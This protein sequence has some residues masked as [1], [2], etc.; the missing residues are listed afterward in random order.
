MHVYDLRDRQTGRDSRSSQQTRELLDDGARSPYG[1]ACTHE[2][3]AVVEVRLGARHALLS[4]AEC[5]TML[6]VAPAPAA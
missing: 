4:C 1:V 3:R 5:G 2:A 6:G